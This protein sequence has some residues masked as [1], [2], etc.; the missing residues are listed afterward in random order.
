M[1]SGNETLIRR[2]EANYIDKN[3][4]SPKKMRKG[5]TTFFQREVLKEAW[6]TTSRSDYLVPYDNS[7]EK[8]T[9]KYSQYVSWSYE[10]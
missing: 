9:T 3:S 6:I 2:H 7:K 1:T 5:S 4:A 8:D 10:R